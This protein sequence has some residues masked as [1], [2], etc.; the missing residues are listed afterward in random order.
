MSDTITILRHSRNALAKTLKTD[1]S[2]EPYD[3]PKYFTRSEARV[4]GI[5]ALS[6]LLGGLEADRHACVIRGRYV[7]DEVA[8]ARDPADPVAQHP[9]YRPGLVRRALDYFDDQPLHA[10]MF[11]VDKFRPVAD[12]VA[13]PVAAI[14][15]YVRSRLPLVFHLSSYHWQLSNTAGLAQNAGVLKAHV[16]FWLATPY[17]SAQLKAW[18]QHHRLEVDVALF[19]TVQVHYT[20]APVLEEGVDDPVPLRS[21]LEAG[22]VAD[23]VDLVITPAEMEAARVGASGGRG[24]RLQQVADADEIA[25]ALADAGL[26]KSQRRDGGLNIECPF[27]DE[28]S[29][30]SGETATIY[31]PPHTGGHALGNFKCMHSHC[32][33]RPRAAFLA[34]LGI[35]EGVPD[36]DDFDEVPPDNGPARPAER[37]GIPEAKHLITDQANAGRI[38]QR[39]GKRLIVA[40]GRWYSW[41]GRR[42]VAD[43]ADVYRYACQLSKLIHAEAAEFENKAR[44]AASDEERK[45]FDAMVKSLKEWAKRSEMKATIEAAVQL[46]R[47][48]L[49]VDEC[50]LDR[51]PWALNCL[52]GTVDLRTGALRKHNPDDYITKLVRLDFDPNATAPGFESTVRRITLEEGRSAPLASFLQRWFGY[53]AT[54]LT[55][56]QVFVVHYGAG[57]NGKS[58]ILDLVADVLGDYATT[59]AP[60]LMVSTGKDRHPTEIADLFGRR[61]VTA[62][63]SSEGGAL[64]EDFVKQA[65]GGDRIKA[66]YMRADFFEFDPTHKLQLLTNHKP[67]I[68]GQDN[69]IWRRVL[70][71]PYLARFASQEEVIAGR[72][73]FV[74]DTKV[75][76]RL[77]SEKQG[78]LAWIVRGAMVWAQEGLQPP[79][80]VLAASKDYQE[81]QDRVLQFVSENCECGADYSEP[82]TCGFGGVYPRY[83]SWCKES[84]FL[85]LSRNRLMAELQRVVPNFATFDAYETGEGGR[86]RKVLRIRGLRLSG[87]E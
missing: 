40:A 78:V 55:R 7:G 54:A 38:V 27:A 13:D 3:D 81:E 76:D 5:G 22:M 67:A 2:V 60:G 68:R 87:V 44:A 50:M 34:R 59:A 43:E 79:D 80:A 21:G 19:N 70:L 48:M 10:V 39:F 75:L 32:D 51:D 16:W 72:A 23:D 77:Q 11:D 69:G 17:T 58:T 1:G 62:H 12:P 52:N 31:W 64:R 82:L 57:S 71:V 9:G 53:C 24:Q 15:E 14:N 8:R 74:K 4:D 37:K 42:W 33:G 29:G 83:T 63:E 65:T 61:M 41:D 25:Q 36:I 28:H 6:S 47:K 86:R 26:V 84:G 73:H 30:G 20:A 49:G 35:V 45:A 56:E 46:A 85:A 66:R 18:A